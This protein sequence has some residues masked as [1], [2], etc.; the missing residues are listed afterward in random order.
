[1]GITTL[2]SIL[3]TTFSPLFSFLSQRNGWG[4]DG[5]TPIQALQAFPEYAHI[6]QLR[7][8]IIGSLQLPVQ[9]VENFSKRVGAHLA[10]FLPRHKV[11][12]PNGYYGLD[13]LL[14]WQPKPQIRSVK[15]TIPK[16][17]ASGTLEQ[18]AGN[19]N[20]VWVSLWGNND[21]LVRSRLGRIDVTLVVNLYAIEPRMPSR[22][23]LG[24]TSTP[25]RVDGDF[26]DPSIKGS[27]GGVDVFLLFIEDDNIDAQR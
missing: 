22:V 7:L 4:L 24:L 10:S 12:N 21:D 1:M 16:C 8:V 14:V 19:N 5:E 20:S 25:V 2:L 27:S 6:K 23:R 17:E 11:L 15:Y 13:P 9:S 26:N 18:G 3:E